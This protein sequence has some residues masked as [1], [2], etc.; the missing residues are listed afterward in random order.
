LI[1][2]PHTASSSSPVSARA[3]LSV[4]RRFNSMMELRHSGGCCNVPFG[5]AVRDLRILPNGDFAVSA[6][7]H[8]VACRFAAAGEGA[9]C[10][11]ARDACAARQRPGENQVAL[12][13]C[14]RRTEL[15]AWFE[16]GT[17]NQDAAR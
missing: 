11:A 2:P 13:G 4:V 5:P 8:R 15:A 6:E 17:T 9:M 1:I 3:A 16:T 14:R 10:H 7:R 12:S